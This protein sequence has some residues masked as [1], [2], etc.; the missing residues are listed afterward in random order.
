MFWLS[1]NERRYSALF[2]AEHEGIRI[3]ETQIPD[4]ADLG[5]PAVGG[6]DSDGIVAAD[7]GVNVFDTLRLHRVEDEVPDGAVSSAAT[8]FRFGISV[9]HVCLSGTRPSAHFQFW[10]VRVVRADPAGMCN[11]VVRSDGDETLI[12]FGESV[13]CKPHDTAITGSGE[14]EQGTI[15][16]P[17][18]SQADGRKSCTLG[19]EFY[20]VLFEEHQIT[21][22][23][24]RPKDFL[25]DGESDVAGT[26]V[27]IRGLQLPGVDLGTID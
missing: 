27:S 26:A 3:V 20:Q 7:V 5:L 24:D 11:F 16:R 22:L 14:R 8:E 12:A 25:R 9:V 2:A 6:A 10:N 15:L 18:K 1:A 23:A 19:S 4:P 17:E 13:H 21:N